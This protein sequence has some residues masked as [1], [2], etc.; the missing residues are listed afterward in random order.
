M[1]I[2]KKLAVVAWLSVLTVPV[3][4]AATPAAAHPVAQATQA[5]QAATIPG[6]RYGDV[7]FTKPVGP[8]RGFIVLFSDKNWTLA[9]SQA[10]DALSKNGAMVVGVDTARYVAKL[11]KE[12]EACHNL[13][14][15][16]EALSHQLE[17]EVQSSRYL[18]PILMGTGQGGV[19]AAKIL[20]Q[21]PDNTVAGALALNPDA[22][23]DARFNLCPPDPTITHA[24]GLPGF[25]NKTVQ[26]ADAPKPDAKSET[27]P[28]TRPDALLALAAPYL[29][30]PE[31][32]RDEDVSDLPLIELPAAHPTNL[33]AI[34]ISGDGGWRDLDKTVAESLQKDGV[35][36]I[37][38]DSLRY[39][40]SAKT[41]G[42]TSHDLARVIQAYSARW[43]SEHV[44]L[45]G[46]SFGADV[47]PFAYNRLPDA[48]RA[49]VSF[50]SLMGFSP[51]ADF[52]IRVTGWLG[53]PA[54]KNAMKVQPELAKLPPAMVQCIY[55]AAE[56]DTLCPA[57]TKT[58]IE[59]IKTS[60][61][62]HFGGDYGVLARRILTSW[63]KQI[64]ARI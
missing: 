51:D 9:D 11:P 60:G 40:W 49:K 47:L 55:G 62:H 7:Q 32:P 27:K 35:S 22:Q 42:Q 18:A 61:D 26:P 23:L 46:Y 38:I 6:G 58:G 8:M 54:S 4:H 14:G 39:F 19:L 45:I 63:Q 36:V 21:A 13:V 3:T 48:V 30:M 53:M 16:A 15:D 52:Q 28:E 41:P 20:A 37:G 34:V 25:F 24:K 56:E 57:L 17:R 5:T 64:A 10:A 31:P 59:V 29:K 43:H 44:A 1:T 2:L 12:K 33:L 50:V